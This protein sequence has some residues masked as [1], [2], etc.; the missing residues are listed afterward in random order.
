MRQHPVN[1]VLTMCELSCYIYKVPRVIL[2]FLCAV[3]FT[4]CDCLR[5][6]LPRKAVKPLRYTSSDFAKMPSLKR[7]VR[8]SIRWKAMQ[9]GADE[10]ECLLFGLGATVGGV[11]HN[12]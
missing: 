11:S 9:G 3:G 10:T 2:A 6:A 8:T 4:A 7:S 12:L 1:D 5:P